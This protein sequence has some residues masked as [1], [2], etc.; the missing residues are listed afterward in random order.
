MASIILSAAAIHPP[1]T[2]SRIGDRANAGQSSYRQRPQSLLRHHSSAIPMPT[3]RP[4][5]RRHSAAN[6]SIVFI[7]G[8]FC[9]VVALSGIPDAHPPLCIYLN[10]VFVCIYFVANVLCFLFE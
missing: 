1:A 8:D 2:T 10:I 5:S 6:M 3:T 4:P 7:H 9:Y